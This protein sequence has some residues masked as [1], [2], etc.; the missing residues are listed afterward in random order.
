LGY[1][2]KLVIYL[3]CYVREEK[4]IS[5]VENLNLQCNA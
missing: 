5:I 4:H 1:R 3:V 2:V